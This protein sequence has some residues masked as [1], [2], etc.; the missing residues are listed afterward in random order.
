MLASRDRAREAQAVI[1]LE[2]AAVDPAAQRRIL[3]LLKPAMLAVPPAIRFPYVAAFAHWADKDEIP[4]LLTMLETPE[5]IEQMPTGANFWAPAI[6]GLARLDAA[7][8]ERIIRK[9][10]G[11]IDWRARVQS[12]L[13][14]M[15]AN[16][17]DKELANRL[18]RLADSK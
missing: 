14:Q 4:T 1:Y 16:A 3:G 12:G 8:A 11:N 17:A 10:R 5:R 7:E 9:R 2:K 6:Q 18:S 15:S 13:R